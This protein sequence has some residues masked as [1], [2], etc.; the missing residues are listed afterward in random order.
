MSTLS[1][2]GVRQCHAARWYSHEGESVHPLQSLT[3]VALNELEIR[4]L[5]YVFVVKCIAFK[6]VFSEH[7]LFS[8]FSEEHGYVLSVIEL[9]TASVV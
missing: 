9:W 6:C 1:A 5:P 7:R 3:S 4:S 2:R 8:C